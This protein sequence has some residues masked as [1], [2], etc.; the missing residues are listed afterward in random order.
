MSNERFLELTIEVL[1]RILND[2]SAGQRDYSHGQV[3]EISEALDEMIIA[4]YRNK[5]KIPL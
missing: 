2:T 3:L 4:Y 1:K 5:N